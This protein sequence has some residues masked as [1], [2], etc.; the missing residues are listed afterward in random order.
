MADD[1]Q[2]DSLDEQ[3]KL[4]VRTEQRL[5]R[6]RNQ[7]DQQLRRMNKLAEFAL[8]TARLEQP[9]EIF[10]CLAQLA[11]KELELDLVLAISRTEGVPGWERTSWR[12]AKRESSSE[13]ELD[14][15]LAQWLEAQDAP[16]TPQV[17]SRFLSKLESLLRL[18]ASDREA[19][20]DQQGLAAC[21]PLRS[22]S[23]SLYGMLIGLRT[24]PASF[25]SKRR[26]GELPLPF[27]Q[28][29]HSHTESALHDVFM[30]SELRE[31]Q[32]RLGESNRQLSLSLENLERTQQQLLQAKKME[33]IGRLAG[34]IAHDFNNLLTVILGHAQLLHDRLPA[35]SR[36]IKDVASVIQAGQRAAEIV[37]HLLSFSR[38]QRRRAVIVDLEDLVR[39]MVQ[40]LGRLIGEHISLQLDVESKLPCIRADHMHLEQILMNFVVNARDA[41][42][43]GGTLTISVRSATGEEESGSEESRLTEPHLAIAVADTGHGMDAQTRTQIFE[44]FFTT[45]ES[46]RGTGMGLATVYGLVKQNDGHVAVKSEVDHGSCFTVYFP[47]VEG[48]PDA[49]A[50]RQAPTVEHAA[51]TILLAEDEKNI[52]DL[53]ADVLRQEGYTVIAAED[54][55]Q[56]LVLAGEVED[57]IDLVVCDVVMPN[58]GG[59]DL[60][61]SL[62]ANDP[63]LPVLFISGYTFD[64]LR[65]GELAGE[66][67]LQK[68][69][70]P[71]ELVARIRELLRRQRLR[72][73]KHPG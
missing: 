34:G 39:G 16:G 66:P 35:A 59:V 12:D 32:S 60:I 65:A 54:G 8:T 47:V 20:I 21:L 4:L 57:R 5:Y 58:L 36:D 11:G 63:S 43:T 44:P 29:I 24:R 45:K 10:D 70:M 33:A 7:R 28:L 38:R 31:Q 37:G 49:P 3:I 14:D 19:L 52:R 15:D 22:S 9:A 17:N 50:E 13:L 71:T 55:A 67:F 61:R 40:M 18:T 42:P 53:F 68:P 69:F 27:I 56:A 25:F 48:R 62:R 23:G 41:M 46:R 30:K 1:P 2:K 64:S 6:A 51:G 26:I 72:I 73:V